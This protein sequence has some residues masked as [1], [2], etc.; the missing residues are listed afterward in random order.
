LLSLLASVLI[1]FYDSRPLYTSLS[2]KVTAPFNILLLT[3]VL[4]L[5]ISTPLEA[6]H[7]A[8]RKASKYT[9][10]VFPSH[11]SGFQKWILKRV[12]KRLQKKVVKAKKQEKRPK[13]EILSVLGFSS[14]LFGLLI[15]LGSSGLGLLFLGLG[16][17]LSLVGLIR[18]SAHP[19][20]HAKVSFLFA[21]LGLLI[22]GSVAL[23][24]LNAAM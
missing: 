24:F 16:L 1:T 15:V 2:M 17:F 10:I 12:A 22:S 18:I 3:F 8:K 21:I 13:P 20:R 23:A 6:V 14:S 5:G 11:L 9:T 4:M 19:R 7:S